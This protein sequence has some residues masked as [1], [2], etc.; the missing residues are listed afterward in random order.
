MKLPQGGKSELAF[1]GSLFFLGLIVFWDTYSVELPAFNLTI[2]P[3][4]FP[5]AVAA[6]LMTL[7]AILFINVL[8][9][10]IAVP[11]GHNPGEEIAK[12]DY[13]AF[14]LVLSSLLAFL[15]LIERAGFIIAAS[16]TFFG[17][18]VAFG[19][20]RHARSALF[21]TL[22]ITLVYL[23]F[24]RFLNVPLPAGIFKGLL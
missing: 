5:Y 14:A 23:A 10:D 17:I 2:S 9:G 18:T 3:K 24:T 15:L 6:A 13:K 12:S 7:S 11:E 20:K 19:N 22:F 4:V 16:L 8:R 21:G 1:V